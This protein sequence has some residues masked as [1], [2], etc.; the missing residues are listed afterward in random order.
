MWP[1]TH[2][3]ER[4]IVDRGVIGRRETVIGI[5]LVSNVSVHVKP[6]IRWRPRQLYVESSGITYRQTIERFSIPINEF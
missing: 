6:G 5:G 1:W 4:E 3:R 2:C